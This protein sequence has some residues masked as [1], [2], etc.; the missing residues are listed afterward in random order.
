MRNITK[1]FT[2]N[3]GVEYVD[4]SVYYRNEFLFLAIYIIHR[5]NKSDNEIYLSILNVID[6]IKFINYMGILDT[7]DIYQLDKIDKVLN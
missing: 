5:M 2:P 1:P 6:N 7:N 3:F 4:L